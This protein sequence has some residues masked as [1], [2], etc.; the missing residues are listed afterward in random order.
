M[1]FFLRPRALM[2]V[3]EHELAIA[4]SEYEWRD[5]VV[6]YRIDVERANVE[7]H[8]WRRFSEIRDFHV[9]LGDDRSFPTRFLLKRSYY[10]LTVRMLQLEKW[11]RAVATSHAVKVEAWLRPTLRLASLPEPI[12]PAKSSASERRCSKESSTTASSDCSGDPLSPTSPAGDRELSA[13]QLRRAEL[14]RQKAAAKA[15]SVMTKEEA[16]RLCR[17]QVQAAEY[18]ERHG[19]VLEPDSPVSPTMRELRYRGSFG[20]DLH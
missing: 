20:E 15:A 14:R 13:F 6:Y 5:N 4:I 19:A 10:N 17:L 9:E 11:L 1:R 7:W 16:E 3:N 18:N 12:S 2:P 8:A